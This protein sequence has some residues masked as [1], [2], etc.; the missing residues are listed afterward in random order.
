MNNNGTGAGLVCEYEGVAFT[1][2]TTVISWRALY[3]APLIWDSFDDFQRA[4]AITGVVVSW[5]DPE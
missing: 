4:E 5:L 3:E 2:G 1:D